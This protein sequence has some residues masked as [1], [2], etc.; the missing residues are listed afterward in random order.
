[1]TVVDNLQQI[2]DIKKDIYDAIADKGVSIPNDEA[3]EN[4]PQAILTI[5]GGGSGATPGIELYD[6]TKAYRQNK[7]VLNVAND[8]VKIYQSLINNNTSALTD[9]TKWKEILADNDLSNL[10]STGNNAFVTKNTAQ[11][12][13]AVKT[14]TASPVVPAPTND[15]DAATKKYVDDAL[16]AIETALA[17]I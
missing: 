14:F 13:S 7:I 15:T 2:L 6:N 16:V 4:Y 9:T 10:S 12:I 1:M 11:T 8:V 3:L 17:S 5:S